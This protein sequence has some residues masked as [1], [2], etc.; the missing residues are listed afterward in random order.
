VQ[1]ETAVGVTVNGA[2]AAVVTSPTGTRTFSA[3]VTLAAEGPNTLT[4]VATDAAGLSTTATRQARRDTQAPVLTLSAPAAGL[5]TK[6]T[7]TPVGGT[8]A[9]ATP[10]TVAANG[11]P[12]PVNGGGAFGAFDFTFGGDPCECGSP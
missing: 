3:T 2:A 10:V 12:L 8:V 6:T 5:V 4:V 9:D 11:V 7:P 1:D